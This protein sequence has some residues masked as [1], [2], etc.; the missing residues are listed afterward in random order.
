MPTRLI[1]YATPV[2]FGPGAVAELAEIVA[3]LGVARP[4]LLSDRGVERAG[5]VAMVREGLAQSDLPAVLDVPPHA[6]ERTVEDAA[7]AFAGCD[8]IVAVGGGSVIDAAKALSLYAA[9]PGPLARFRGGS[10]LRF[11]R[12]VPPVIAVPTTA[13]TGSEISRGLAVTIATGERLVLLDRALYPAIAVCD[14]ALTLTLPP[15]LTAATA[16]DALSHCVEGFLSPFAGPPFDTVAL[17]G[18][19]RLWTALPAILDNPGSLA[20]RTEV[21]LGAV[22]G[23]MAMPLG[24]GAAHAL[25]VPLDGTGLHHG[26][27]VGALLAPV[28]RRYEGRL[29]D[30]AQALRSA[31]GLAPQADIARA[32]AGFVRHAGLP[33]RLDR[34]TA[35]PELEAATIIAALGSHY[36]RCSPIPF[37][38]G[39]YGAVLAEVLTQAPSD[40]AA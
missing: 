9:A 21:M 36:H 26:T 29:G 15:H 6:T 18:A 31:L 19:R 13:G 1:P 5:L 11:P 27:V 32:L 22:E 3:E 37:A 12:A 10:G 20:L 2:R 4:L 8:G 24:L 23:G 16:V 17:D 25:G 38:A 7:A 33:D 40:V 28:L 14:P 39:D 35:G 34:G 30:K